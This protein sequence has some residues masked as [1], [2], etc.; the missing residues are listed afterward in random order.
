MKNAE[1]QKMAEN[2]SKEIELTKK[3]QEKSE[4]DPLSIFG[5]TKELA[6]I[7]HKREYVSFIRLCKSGKVATAT[8][9]AKALGVDRNTII[10]WFKTSKARRALLESSDKY[11][12]NIEAS[13]DW[14]AHQWLLQQQLLQEES[15]Q[16]TSLGGLTI[17]VNPVTEQVIEAK[18]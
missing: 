4:S 12:Q 7:K 14:K 17:N 8:I 13:K 10:A 16:L 1:S 9:T 2:S 11:V 5:D 18:D 6:H 15:N 3:K